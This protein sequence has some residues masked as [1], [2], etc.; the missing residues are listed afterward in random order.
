M[1]YTLLARCSCNVSMFL[2]HSPVFRYLAQHWLPSSCCPPAKPVSVAQCLSAAE[3]NLFLSARSQTSGCGN[4]SRPILFRVKANAVRQTRNSAAESL[5]TEMSNLHLSCKIAAQTHFFSRCE[6]QVFKVF[7]GKTVI[8]RVLA[9]GA[10]LLL[11]KEGH[12]E[13]FMKFH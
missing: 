8:L 9:E 5:R 13:Q 12:C 4:L 10:F 1:S 6:W 7:G 2:H 3:S 11:T